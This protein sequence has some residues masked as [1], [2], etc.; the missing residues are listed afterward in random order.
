[1]L[2]AKRIKEIRKAK[3]LIQDEIADLLD[4]EQSTYNGYEN[5]AGNLKFTTIVKIA[6]ALKCSLPFLVDIHSQVYDEDVWKKTMC[7]TSR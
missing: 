7:E 1:M 3:G 4:I 5:E 6:E 2:L